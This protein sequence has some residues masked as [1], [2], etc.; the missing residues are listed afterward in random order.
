LSRINHLLRDTASLQRSSDDTGDGRGGYSEDFSEIDTIRAR[1]SRT[2]RGRNRE[3]A[4]KDERLVEYTV[5]VPASMD[6]QR[7]DRLVG[8]RVTPL[9]VIQTLDVTGAS[10][11]EVEVEH[12]QESNL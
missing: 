4:D 2:R 8:L 12:I 7:G 10:H 5:Y 9:E 6:L 3:R 1:L 11:Q